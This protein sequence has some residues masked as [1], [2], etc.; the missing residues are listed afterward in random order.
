MWGVEKNIYLSLLWEIESEAYIFSNGV[1]SQNNEKF[2]TG[3][4]KEIKIWDVLTGVEK[5]TLT[6]HSANVAN[7]W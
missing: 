1:F 5:V 2:V 3:I 7:Y 6:G 4:G